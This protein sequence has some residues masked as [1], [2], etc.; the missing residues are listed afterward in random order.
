MTSNLPPR[1]GKPLIVGLGGAELT[2]WNAR[3]SPVRPA[4]IICSAEH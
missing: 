2:I 3:G 1:R 4:G